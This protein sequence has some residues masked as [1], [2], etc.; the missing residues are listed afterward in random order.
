MCGCRGWPGR[1]PSLTGFTHLKRGVGSIRRALRLQP[2]QQK[3]NVGGVLPTGDVVDGPRR[4]SDSAEAADW[5]EYGADE[6]PSRG[7]RRRRPQARY[8]VQ[9]EFL[10]PPAWI[11]RSEEGKFVVN[12]DGE[13]QVRPSSLL[14]YQPGAVVE[15]G[16]YRIGG[17]RLPSPR[18]Q[19]ILRRELSPLPPLKPKVRP[20]PY[21]QPLYPMTLLSSPQFGRYAIPSEPPLPHSKE[22]IRSSSPGP[23][24]MFSPSLANFSD[25]SSVRQPSS[26]ERS[27]PSRLSSS[28]HQTAETPLDAA[29][30][31]N[32]FFPDNVVL[33]P[34]VPHTRYTRELPALL[35][36]H[37]QL[38]AQHSLSPRTMSPTPQMRT[39][40]AE[41]HTAE[42]PGSASHIHNE[43]G[44]LLNTDGR[45]FHSPPPFRPPPPPP[46]YQRLP[47]TIS[48]P[49]ASQRP[50]A[51]SSP[52]RRRHFSPE[53]HPLVRGSDDPSGSRRR[54]SPL[55]V[56]VRMSPARSQQRLSERSRSQIVE[57]SPQ[58]QSSSSGFDSKNTSQQNQS[59][60]S[61]SGQSQFLP[62]GS[63]ALWSRS[64][65]LPV[66]SPLRLP[67]STYV[68]WP[69]K[70]AATPAASSLLDASV[71]NHY[72]F[73]TTQSPNESGQDPAPAV[74]TTMMASTSR[75]AMD[76][77]TD[78]SYDQGS[79]V[80]G[81]G[82]RHRKVLGPTP[83]G[84]PENIEARVQAMK[85]EFQEYRKR[86]ARGLLESAC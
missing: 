46:V 2:S 51:T 30:G 19:P 86:R 50:L 34:S 73:D 52:P 29:E 74:S 14:K 68:N 57:Y 49:H 54:R 45:H 20:L 13:R 66:R 58:S 43:F 5:L 55:T 60:H 67:D 35:P 26:A 62:D 78:P 53:A 83:A 23:G 40:R 69:V 80:G 59:S 76:P 63:S 84:R 27:F 17:D 70:P 72:E 31:F 47:Y 71:D 44:L 3:Q 9:A 12:D 6:L 1:L 22:V 38:A 28:H 65:P 25:M 8:S 11:S 39:V 79:S 37:Q 32:Q 16:V 7:S 41:I 4:R 15:S 42:I 21:P 82:S 64:P 61:G 85:E 81:A 24:L 48:Y 10:Q 75:A 18:P 77:M 33:S 36:I 56:A